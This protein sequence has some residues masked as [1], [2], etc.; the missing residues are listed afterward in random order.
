MNRPTSESEWDL[1]LTVQYGGETADKLARAL[2]READKFRTVLSA[3]PAL[4]VDRLLPALDEAAAT[5]EQAA[6]AM[7]RAQEVEG[8]EEFDGAARE[9]VAL[10]RKAHEQTLA[11]DRLVRRG[12]GSPEE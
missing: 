7:R 9:A 11:V 10:G 8:T 2:R 12:T 5:A 6:E 1:H 3:H 4:D